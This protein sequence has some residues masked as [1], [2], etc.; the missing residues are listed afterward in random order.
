M[1]NQ[2]K[3]NWQRVGGAG[4][5]DTLY[6]C[7]T[8]GEEFM[9]SMDSSASKPVFGCSYTLKPH[10]VEVLLDFLDQLTDI[11][12]CAGCNDWKYPVSWTEEQKLEYEKASLGNDYDDFDHDSPI[13]YA[14]SGDSGIVYTLM[15]KLRNK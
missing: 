15:R 4:M 12:A 10:E 8:C 11:Q 9:E 3:H 2:N 6:K 1:E 7:D 13:E 5:W 14:T